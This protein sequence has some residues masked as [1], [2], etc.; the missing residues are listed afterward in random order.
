[1]RR[2]RGLT[3]AEVAAGAGVPTPVVQRA[4]QGATPR[5][6]WQLALATF[7]GLRPSEIWRVD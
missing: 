2:D 5:P 1:L 4:E 3:Q 7:Y 6:R